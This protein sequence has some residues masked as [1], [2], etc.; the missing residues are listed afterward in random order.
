MRRLSWVDAVTAEPFICGG[1]VNY[2]G[3]DLNP[4]GVGSPCLGSNVIHYI[5]ILLYFGFTQRLSA[6]S[7]NRPSERVCPVQTAYAWAIMLI[8]AREPQSRRH[9]IPLRHRL[10][11]HV[12][13]QRFASTRQVFWPS[14]A[15]KPPFPSRASRGWGRPCGRT[16]GR[17]W[18]CGTH[19]AGRFCLHACG[20]VCARG[21]QTRGWCG[22][23]LR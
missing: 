3:L 15:A 7:A 1:I 13:F 8:Q 11:L 9:R 21:A 4:Y 18:Q 2:S 14:A 23:A 20:G 16:C 5:Y 19:S 17:L 10:A 22:N 6:L 12:R